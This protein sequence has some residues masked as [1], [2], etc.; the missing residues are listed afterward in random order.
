MSKSFQLEKFRVNRTL[1][2]FLSLKYDR[3]ENT[4]IFNPVHDQ[5]LGVAQKI[6]KDR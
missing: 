6:L 2:V 3:N 4:I 5:F 1:I